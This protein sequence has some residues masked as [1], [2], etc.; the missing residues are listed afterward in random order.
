MSIPRILLKPDR[1]HPAI[2]AEL[3][4]LMMSGRWPI[5]VIAITVVAIGV[6]AMLGGPDPLVIASLIVILATLAT[7]A[8]LITRFLRERR[9]GETLGSVVA[10]ERRYV[11]VVVPYALA[12]GVFNYRL[13]MHSQEAVHLLVVAETY[14][15]CAGM[16]SRAFMRPRLCAGLV[17]IGALPTALALALQSRDLTGFDA[18]TYAS[19]ALLCVFFAL[20]S[21]ETVAHLYRA[22]VDQL[23]TRRQFAGLAR[24]DALTGLANRLVM[25][26]ILE[27]EVAAVDPG[28]PHTVALLLIDLDEFK[29]VN[30]RYGHPEGDHLLCDVAQRLRDEIRGDD[31][32]IRL[33]GDEFAIIQRNIPDA[34]GAIALGDRI[35]R[36]LAEPFGEPGRI[37]QIGASI[38]IATIDPGV[39][40][41]DMLIERAD[42]ALYRAK[43]SGGNA[44]RL[45]RQDPVLS[46]AA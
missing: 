38:G 15:F 29:G 39:I 32:A 41:V 35:V 19:V 28:S 46:V 12:L 25:R 26:E 14:G 5:A 17:L 37:S 7:R 3:V 2:H 42:A 1:L 23:T 34:R 18:V 45:W 30:D 31:I 36:L 22:L 11:R 13:M 8:H 6:L 9:T 40:D 44:V 43:R 10:D 21:L 20:S 33:G 4:T 24:V 27:Q 16:V